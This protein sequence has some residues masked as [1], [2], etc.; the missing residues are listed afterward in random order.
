LLYRSFLLSEFIPIIRRRYWAS[1]LSTPSLILFGLRD[2]ALAP[3]LLKGYAPY[4]E[5]LKV[6]LVQNSGH[7]IAEDQPELVT[8]RALDFFVA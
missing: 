2:F 7:F 4:A 6:E 3:E 5:N 8:K 1:R